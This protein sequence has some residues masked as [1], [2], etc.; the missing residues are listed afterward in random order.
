M[1]C[2]HLDRLLNTETTA[3][4]GCLVSNEVKIEGQTG[5]SKDLGQFPVFLGLRDI[6]IFSGTLG[7]CDN[8]PQFEAALFRHIE[9]NSFDLL[10]FRVAWAA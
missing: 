2:L 1:Y 8:I 7:K 5:L 6:S 10:C 4:F 3:E 9:Y